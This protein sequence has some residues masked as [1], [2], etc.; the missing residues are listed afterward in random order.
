MSWIELDQR[1]PQWHQ[2]RRKHITASNIAAICGH[3][4]YKTPL[5]VYE[6]MVTGKEPFLNQAMQHGIDTE[7]EARQWA[8]FQSGIDF[9]PIC[10]TSEEIPWAAASIDGY[11]PLH[12][13]IL[14]IKCPSSRRV[15]LDSMAGTLPKYYVM[16]MQWQL[17]VTKATKCLFVSY[18]KEIGTFQKSPHAVLH[19]LTPDFKLID[20]MKAKAQDFWKNHI[21]AQSPPSA[22][23]KD[24]DEEGSI[25]WQEIA[26]ETLFWINKKKEL[27]DLLDQCS[28]EIDVR[29]TQLEKLAGP[30]SRVKGGGLLYNSYERRGEVDYSAIPQ[31]AHI[32]LDKYRKPSKKIITLKT[33]LYE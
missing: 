19:T 9:K 15:H 26:Q 33:H 25:R 16:Q 30:R 2:W 22:E 23:A 20:Q 21:V 24:Y 28:Y 27:S 10:A 11:C 14:E 4:P 12:N 31:I 7:D 5:A 18:Y 29:K 8:I 13:A 17:F 6:E 3:H 1:S 32:D